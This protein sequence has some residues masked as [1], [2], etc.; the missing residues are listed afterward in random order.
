MQ[1]PRQDLVPI[2]TSAVN[3]AGAGVLGKLPQNSNHFF[4]IKGLA[5][6]FPTHEI[7]VL[8][9]LH[10]DFNISLPFLLKYEFNLDL[11]YSELQCIE[12]DGTKINVPFVHPKKPTV[13]C[14]TIRPQKLPKQL[15]IR[16]HQKV[17]IQGDTRIS[18]GDV[19]PH[20]KR[21]RS[22]SQFIDKENS[23]QNWSITEGPKHIENSFEVTNMS[24]K[25]RTIDQKFVLGHLC[26][27]VLLNKSDVSISTALESAQLKTIKEKVRL[28]QQFEKIFLDK[29]HLLL[30]RFRDVISFTDRPG[31]TDLGVTYIMTVDSKPVYCKENRL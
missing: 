6:E 8:E 20:L 10:Q 27:I 16:P 14:A 1:I 18:N 15:I 23:V 9:N 2:S 26:Q 7:D 12:S 22:E 31:L 28:E 29:V 25:D 24:N 17:V 13:S 19:T 21:I 30:M 11:K 3:Q 5:K 4:K